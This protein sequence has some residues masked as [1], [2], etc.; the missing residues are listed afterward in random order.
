MGKKYV[1]NKETIEENYMAPPT[2]DQMIM[3][4]FRQMNENQGLIDVS[5]F[6]PWRIGLHATKQ[7]PGIKQVWQKIPDPE[8]WNKT[9]K[10]KN[11]MHNYGLAAAG[12]ASV[13][14]NILRGK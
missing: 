5:A 2:N 12:G 1:D 4:Y 6:L 7:V 14:D 3:N 11:S 8:I 9:R 10:A 13:V